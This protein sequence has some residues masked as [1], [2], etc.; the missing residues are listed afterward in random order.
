M[1][2]GIVM[3]DQQYLPQVVGLLDAA[4]ERGWPTVCFLTDTGVNALRDAGFIERA[5]A[6]P[7][8]ITLCE[9]SVEKHA[10]GS[11]D[12]SAHAD[13]VVVG[14]QYQN[15]ELAHTCDKVVVF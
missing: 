12:L 8:S 9:H 11:V 10:A 6:T 3:T 7:N 2:L 1:Q 5:R 15:A 13:Y 14:G 4:R